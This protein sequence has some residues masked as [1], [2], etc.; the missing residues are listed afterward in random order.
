MR[1]TAMRVQRLIRGGEPGRH[2]AGGDAPRGLYSSSTARK[3][4]IGS[5][6]TSSTGA[7]IG[8]AWARPACSAWPKRVPGRARRGSRSSMASTRSSHAAP[9][10]PNSG[11][12]R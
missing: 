2:L 1:L 8:W 10:R 11:P 6:A 9:R 7:A 3:R 4:R 12:P 5:Y